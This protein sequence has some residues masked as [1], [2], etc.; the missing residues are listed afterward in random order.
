MSPYLLLG[1]FY[2]EAAL[3]ETQD[4]LEGLCI[5]SGLKTSWDPSEMLEHGWGAKKPK[6]SCLDCCH[7]DPFKDTN[8]GG[9]NGWFEKM[10][11]LAALGK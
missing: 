2:W 5:P 11:Y 6:I 4:K 1:M 7:R 3:Y 8:W 9:G 10:P